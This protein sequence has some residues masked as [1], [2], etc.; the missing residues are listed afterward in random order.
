MSV[1]KNKKIGYARCS[2]NYQSTSSQRL[3][4]KRYGCD[5][6]MEEIE[7]GRR[8]DRPKLQKLLKK[9]KPGDSLVVYKLDRLGRSTKQLLF[10]IDEL[11]ERGI[12]FVSISDSIDTT[13]SMGKFMFTIM[14]A[15]AEMEADLIRER[16][17]S[18]LESAKS[19]GRVG[20][21][22]KIPKKIAERIVVDYQK[23]K[24]SIN[25]IAEKHQVSVRTVYNY[26]RKYETK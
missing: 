4:L 20:G 7:S 1:T 19:K 26:I 3:A 13:T 5:Y 16:V 18:G 23:Q 17:K 11:K 12:H 10:L 8:E 22:P 15:F 14:S 25:K 24:L 9:L 2:T 6:I 21:R